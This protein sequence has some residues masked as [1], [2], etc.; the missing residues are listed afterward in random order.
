MFAVGIGMAPLNVGKSSNRKASSRFQPLAPPPPTPFSDL[1]LQYSRIPVKDQRAHVQKVRDEIYDDHPYPCLGLF[2]FMQFEICRHPL[3]NPYVLPTLT[4]SLGGNQ[5]DEQ[6]VFLDLGTCLG[7]DLRFLRHHAKPPV[8]ASRLWGADLHPAFIEAGYKLFQDQDWLPRDHMLAPVDVL[9]DPGDGREDKLSALE[10][11]VSIVQINSVFHLFD[12]DAQIRC[13]KRILHVLDLRPS[14]TTTATGD[15]KKRR[16]SGGGLL[17]KLSKVTSN[18]ADTGRKR[19]LIIG[20][21]IGSD[22]PGPL[23][24]HGAAVEISS[25]SNN[26]N[27][28]N[29]APPPPVSTTYRHSDSTWISFWHNT[30]PQA[31]VQETFAQRDGT[32]VQ[33]GKVRFEA[34]CRMMHPDVDTTAEWRGPNYR[35]LIWWVWVW[36]E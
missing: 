3:Y 26:N 7:Q 8:P 24:P 19:A 20:S 25:E 27:N 34:Q 15:D 1:L 30:V 12:M 17:G 35:W 4:R 13:A 36:S 16:G 2:R 14:S 29:S 22:P 33:G 11:K 5:G 10:G 31:I 23:R 32:V 21:Q 28:K 9:R 6:P 18:K